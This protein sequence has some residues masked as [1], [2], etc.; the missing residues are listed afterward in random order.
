MENIKKRKINL[1]E[2]K[3][4]RNLVDEAKEIL[5]KLNKDELKENHVINSNETENTVT[6]EI[7]I[8]NSELKVTNYD[9]E[10]H[11]QEENREDELSKLEKEKEIREQEEN[12]KDE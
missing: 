11:E 6:D 10:I 1:D 2:E 7:K 5:K 3:E 9:E 12:Q 4:E 8:I